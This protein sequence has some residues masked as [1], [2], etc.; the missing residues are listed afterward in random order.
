MFASDNGAALD[1]R[2]VTLF[3]CPQTNTFYLYRA[4]SQVADPGF[5][6]EGMWRFDGVFS[7]VGAF[8]EKADWNR[9]EKIEARNDE[10][11]GESRLI[12]TRLVPDKPGL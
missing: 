1:I 9:V 11:E 6:A 3:A 8:T 10:D 12:L 7:S 2:R 4:P 5:E